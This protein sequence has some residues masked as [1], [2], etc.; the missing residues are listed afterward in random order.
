MALASAVAGIV[1]SEQA[2]F[3]APVTIAFPNP[4]AVGGEALDWEDYLP[5]GAVLH[6]AMCDANAS[7]HY[8]Y[9]R[10]NKK[11]LAYVNATG[12]QAGAIDLS[13]QTGIVITFV[14]A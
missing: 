13:G 3:F 10:T 8:Q 14:G 6:G 7:Y 9:D 11:V 12:A 4:Y 5:E 2:E 1:R